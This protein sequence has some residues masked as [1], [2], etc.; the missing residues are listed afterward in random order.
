MS[1]GALSRERLEGEEEAYKA[2]AQYVRSSQVF[3]KNYNGWYSYP[4]HLPRLVFH[5]SCIDISPLLLI[6]TK[7]GSVYFGRIVHYDN[8]VSVFRFIDFLGQIDDNG[9]FALVNDC[10]AWKY[11]RQSEAVE[12]LK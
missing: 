11:V 4:D 6:K 1:S 7:S 12:L 9:E 5:D 2:Q 3:D 10:I 8:V